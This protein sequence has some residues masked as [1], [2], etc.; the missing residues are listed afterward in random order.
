M[1]SQVSLLHLLEESS[2]P[3]GLYD[4]IMD[5]ECDTN[6]DNVVIK[7]KIYILVQSHCK[8]DGVKNTFDISNVAHLSLRQ[9]GTKLGIV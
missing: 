7:I 9:G 6:G 5:C 4:K 3:I 2:A 1:Q 8:C